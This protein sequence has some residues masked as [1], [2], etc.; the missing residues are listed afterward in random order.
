MHEL[1]VI[2]SFEGDRLQVFL[3]SMLYWNLFS[4]MMQCLGEGIEEEEKDQN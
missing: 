4:D 3:F 2:M 1:N